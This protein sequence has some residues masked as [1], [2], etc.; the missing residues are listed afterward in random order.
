MIPR[1][2]LHRVLVPIAALTVL[3]GLAQALLPRFVLGL[4]GGEATPGGAHSF[5]I[6]GMFMVLFGG[7]LL[8][9]LLTPGDHRVAVLWAGLQKLGAFAAVSL[10]VAR[11]L[12]SVLALGVAGFDLLSGVLILLYLRGAARAPRAPAGRPPARRVAEPV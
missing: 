11:G 3:S 4:I 7:M 5:G 1:S 6:V 12:F 8:H 2:P 10:G 9:A